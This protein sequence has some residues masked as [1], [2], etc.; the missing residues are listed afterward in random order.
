MIVLEFFVRE[1]IPPVQTQS[2]STRMTYEGL[3]VRAG[4]SIQQ[5][6]GLHRL[7]A[8]LTP[9]TLERLVG[10]T[11]RVFVEQEQLAQRVQGKVTLD[12]LF[13]VYDGRGKRLLVRLSL[14]DLLFDRSCGYKAVHET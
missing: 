7:P 13:L 6:L 4:I 12:V 14:E 5:C 9:L 11:Q 10:L 2:K 8:V 1:M 3:Y